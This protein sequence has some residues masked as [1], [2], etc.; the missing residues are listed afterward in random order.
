[1]PNAS[2]LAN[3]RGNGLLDG[4]YGRREKLLL[5]FVIC[6]SMNYEVVC[7]YAIIQQRG[8]EIYIDKISDQWGQYLRSSP[9]HQ[10]SGG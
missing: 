2:R 10:E 9:P 4:A 3:S 8:I 6:I 1:M 5:R 7:L